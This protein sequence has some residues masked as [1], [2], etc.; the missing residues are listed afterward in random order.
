M[1][2]F[3]ILLFLSFELA[4]L[5]TASP[6]VAQTVAPPLPET[7][8][9]E[10]PARVGS[11]QVQIDGG[12]EQNPADW[13]STLKYY[14]NGSFYCTSTIVGPFVIITAAHCLRPNARMVVETD[15]RSF[16][17]T[18]TSHPGYND[19]RNSN[20]YLFSDVALCK[21]DAKFPETALYENLDLQIARVKLEM[22]LF[23]LGY[24]CRDVNLQT[25][26]GQLYGGTSTVLELPSASGGHI[27]TG[28]GVV[29]CL[30]DSGG[31]AYMLV[32]SAQVTSPRS[33]VGINSGNFA[34]NRTSY[35]A[36]FTDAVADFV[37]RWSIDN[38]VTIC[39]V[40][41]DVSG[42]RSRAAL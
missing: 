27:Q 33:I 5:V 9:M 20:K 6:S 2:L 37:R 36:G 7:I 10:R 41:A 38:T 14:L 19:D 16:T 1:P 15:N 42:C 39:G 3:L 4:V 18:C 25:D 8:R 24:G 31:A 13:P 22:N 29:I 11:G 17:L 34:G 30:G 21:S 35:I 40:H 28:N 26:S 32:N 12:S 23:L